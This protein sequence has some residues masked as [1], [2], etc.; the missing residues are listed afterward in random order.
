MSSCEKCWTDSYDRGDGDSQYERYSVLL[1]E[2]EANP[3]TPEQQAGQWWDED[4]Q[5]DTRK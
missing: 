4:K 2:R 5:I 1:K 3:C